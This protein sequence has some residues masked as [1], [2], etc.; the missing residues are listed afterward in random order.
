MLIYPAIDLLDGKCVRLTQG[1]YN[2]VQ[3]YGDDPVE[4]ARLFLG[5]GAEWI[6]VVDLGA[7]KSGISTQLHFIEE[8][9]NLGLYVQVGGGIRSMSAVQTV[10]NAGA[11][12]T[13]AGTALV[14]DPLFRAEFF[15]LGEPAVAGV[16]VR[17]GLVR[18]SGW[19]EGADL[20]VNAFLKTLEAEGA[21]LVVLTDIGKDGMLLG[22]N[23]DLL[24]SAMD[25]CRLNFIQSGGISSIQDI[26]AL[27]SLPNQERINGVI[28]GK[29]IYEGRIKV[30]EALQRFPLS[31]SNRK[32]D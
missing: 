32:G 23:L 13:V 16:D 2:Q 4:V 25:S 8:I 27:S 15:A 1:D 20:E 14:K 6:H 17:D 26:E 19:T 30:R 3:V 10:L 12:R 5:E 24:R 29:A 28:V 22:P 18:V 9:A 31:P 21:K 11:S 7:A